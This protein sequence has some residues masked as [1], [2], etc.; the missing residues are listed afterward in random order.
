MLTVSAGHDVSYL[1]KA[2]AGGREGYYSSAVTSGEPPG[3]WYGSGARALGLRGEA[4]EQDVKALFSR[5]IDPRDER[6]SQPDQWPEAATL[7]ARPMASWSTAE[8]RLAK[9]V[10]REEARLAPTTGVPNSILMPE[11]REKLRLQAERAGR[12]AVMFHDATFSVQKSVTVLHTAFARMENEATTAELA[13]HWGAH[14]RAVE[15]AIWAGNRA[16]LDYLEDRAGYSRV[17]HHGGKAGRWTDAHGFVVAS[18]F[19]H[20]SREKQPQL[21]IHNAIL[22]RVECAD[23]TFRTIDG[24]LLY[25]ERG[26]ASAIGERTMEEHLHRTLG[27]TFATRPDGKAREIVGISQDVIDTF[28]VRRRK[29]SEKA[30]QLCR[31]FETR[32]GR[33]PNAL[34]RDRLSRRATFAT[35]AAKS[36]DGELRKDMLARFDRELRAEVGAK[37]EQVAYDVLAVE[38]TTEPGD[39][40]P[41]RVMETALAAVQAKKSGWTRGDLLREVGAALPDQLGIPAAEVRTLIE[42]LTNRAISVAEMSSSPAGSTT[43]GGA[44]RLQEDVAAVVPEELRLADGSSAYV[45]PGS[46]T[47]ALPDQLAA[48]RALRRAGRS[49]G[50]TRFDSAEVSDVLRGLAAEGRALKPDQLAAV[51]GVLTSGARVEALVGP[52]GAGKSW[53]VGALRDAWAELSGG[54]VLGLAAS[55]IATQVLRDEGLDAV[56]IAKFLAEREAGRQELSHA[57]LVVVDES[58]MANTAHLD[59]IRRAVESSGAKLLLTG[60]HRQLAAVGAGGAFRLVAETGSAYELTEV[61]R[62]E[63]R[64]EGP[65]S[66]RLRSGDAEALLEYDR[67]GRLQDGGT[68][69]MT[70]W[71]AMR[72]WLGDTVMGRR[73]LLIVNTNEEAAMLSAQCRAELVKLGRVDDSRTA[74]LG[75]QGVEAGVGDV[76][77]ARRNARQLRGYLANSR[78]P[79]NRELYRVTE[80]REDG[81]I[82]MVPLDAPAESIALPA[83]YV[84]EHLALGYAVTGHGAQGQTVHTG[85]YV[86]TPGTDLSAAYPG[87]TRGTIRNTAYVETQSAAADAP[88]GDVAERK[89]PLAV[90]LQA[91]E[92]ADTEQAAVSQMEQS[93]EEARSVKTLVELFTDAAQLAQA[94]RVERMFDELAV[95][96]V[97]TPDERARLAADTGGALGRLLR[98][99]E[100]AGLDPKETVRDVAHARSLDGAANVAAVLHHRISEATRGAAPAEDTFAARVPRVGGVWQQRLEQLAALTDDRAEQLGCELADGPAVGITDRERQWALEAFGD[101]STLTAEQRSEWVERAGRVAAYRE[102][103]GEEAEERPI[104]PAPKADQTEAHAAWH[105]AW[106][107]LGRPEADREEAELT[108]GQLSLRVRAYEREETWAPPWVGDRLREVSQQAEEARHQLAMFDARREDDYAER[109]AIRWEAEQ[110]AAEL[111]AERQELELIDEARAAWY[112]ETIATREAAQ[113]AADELANRGNPIGEEPDRCTAEEWLAA[114]QQARAEDDEH[115]PVTET[116]VRAEQTDERDVEVSEQEAVTAAELA[117]AALTIIASREAEYEE[118]RTADQEARTE[119]QDETP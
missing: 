51:E 85:H 118:Y 48:E 104:G 83:R 87:M 13:E 116:D 10:D 50:A 113:R 28:S 22:N 29:I 67:H 64:W 8:E 96:G 26:A 101:P 18:F 108:D 114:E 16:L 11:Q 81:G 77:Q 86:A 32:V 106:R 92:H 72:G 55:E 88:N 115:R 103:A 79:I 44:V 38:P 71:K 59:L 3:R 84:A 58:G 4:S 37:L 52:A 21:H 69:E 47:Y 99:V 93:I 17:G 63:S 30:D 73:S 45:R 89:T 41:T 27:V 105:A 110:R 107:A 42:S 31:E 20:D 109:A 82:T 34:E 61:R 7:G 56:N 15:A 117:R 91:V 9:L 53:T 80:V 76:V 43:Y 119:W 90:L 49:Q 35:R 19:Q 68:A 23:R 12:S 112:A 33:P 39:F 36:H 54:R 40:S 57:D 60:D 62:F 70:R 94:G 2:V 97:F 5:M 24:Q 66:L 98:S 102:L 1:T 46:T 100:L 111:E 78:G 65:A 75:L 6:F 14:R 25:A 95:E 74:E